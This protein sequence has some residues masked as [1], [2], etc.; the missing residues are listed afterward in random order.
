MTQ[1]LYSILLYH[2]QSRLE[3]ESLERAIDDLNA[4]FESTQDDNSE[5]RALLINVYK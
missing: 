1:A 4:T 5:E 2:L 3:G